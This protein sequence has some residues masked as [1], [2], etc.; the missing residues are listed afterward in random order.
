MLRELGEKRMDD[1]VLIMR[2]EMGLVRLLERFCH[3][4]WEN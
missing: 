3:A 4:P 1:G 2:T